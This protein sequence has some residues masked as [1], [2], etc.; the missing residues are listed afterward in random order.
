MRKLSLGEFQQLGFG[1]NEKYS[2]D[3]ILLTFRGK[4][5]EVLPKPPLV[6]QR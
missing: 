1:I 2:K 5:L 6:E 4:P 3:G